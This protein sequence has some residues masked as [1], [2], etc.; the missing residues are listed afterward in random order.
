MLQLTT[1]CTEVLHTIYKQGEG[2]DLNEPV[3]KNIFLNIPFFH[4]FNKSFT[5]HCYNHRHDIILHINN[6]G[7]S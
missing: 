2:V 4:M 5:D 1:Y 7:K 6:D 3:G